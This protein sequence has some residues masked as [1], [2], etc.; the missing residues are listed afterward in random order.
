MPEDYIARQIN[1]T[2]S[3]DTVSRWTH[4]ALKEFDITQVLHRTD[5][6]IETLAFVFSDGSMTP[7]S[8]LSGQT[9]THALSLPVGEEIGKIIFHA[10]VFLDGLEIYDRENHIIGEIDALAEIEGNQKK[11]LSLG[12]REKIC[13]VRFMFADPTWCD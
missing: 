8:H 2:P 4:K 5:Q 12:Q 6:S 10:G 7:P 11:V 1:Y 9:F 13:G 3:R